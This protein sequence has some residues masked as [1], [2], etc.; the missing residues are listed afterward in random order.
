MTKLMIEVAN[1]YPLLTSL[2]SF[3]QREYNK[4]EKKIFTQM[5]KIFKNCLKK[6]INLV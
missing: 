4:V 5:C 6:I 1:L 2:F 3:L